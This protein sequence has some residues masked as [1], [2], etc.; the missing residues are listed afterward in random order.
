MNPFSRGSYPNRI[1]SQENRLAS[2]GSHFWRKG[3]K[4]C[5]DT[6]VYSV[7]YFFHY[8]LEFF[9]FQNNPKN[10]DPSYRSKPLELFRKGKTRIIAKIQFIS[11]ISLFVVILERGKLRLIAREIQK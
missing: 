2:K 1:F 11:L 9:S 4:Y 3:D 6:N 7:P 10:L 8:K 5:N